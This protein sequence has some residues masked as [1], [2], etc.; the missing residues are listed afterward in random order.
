M[1]LLGWIRLEEEGPKTG[2]GRESRREVMAWV[3]AV[4]LGLRRGGF[5][6][7]PG[8]GTDSM[9]MAVKGEAGGEMKPNPDFRTGPRG[10]NDAIC[11]HGEPRGIDEL[12][13]ELVEC[14]VP[15]TI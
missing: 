15:E 4:A 8:G 12:R 3:G 5:E 11:W 13:L 1:I 7:W 14:Q 6:S 2:P 9:I 10:D